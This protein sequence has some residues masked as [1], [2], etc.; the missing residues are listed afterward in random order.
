MAITGRELIDAARQAVP[1]ISNDRLYGRL[2]SGAPLVI[3]D[4]REKD[5]WDQGHIPQA[6]LLP[7][8]RLEGRIE[9]MVPDKDML[10][11]TH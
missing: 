5:E 11:V 2:Q 8:G 10:I 9:Q 4:V 7:R 6:T 3:L 1:K